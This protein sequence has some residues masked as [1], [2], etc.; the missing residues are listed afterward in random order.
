MSCCG[1]LKII[2]WVCL[3]YL[4]IEREK[5]PDDKKEGGD[6]KGGEERKKGINLYEDHE[7]GGNGGFKVTMLMLRLVTN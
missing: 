1:Q 3:T 6:A 4:Y 7:R 5:M 2:E